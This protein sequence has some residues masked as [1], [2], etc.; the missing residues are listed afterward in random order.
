MSIKFWHSSF[1]ILVS[2]LFDGADFVA[3]LGCLFVLL[4]RDGFLHFAAKADQLRLL[5]GAA[6]TLDLDLSDPARALARIRI[7][8]GH[9]A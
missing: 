7:P 3:K 6:G 5:F 9:A 8:Q 4:G 2:R 1:L